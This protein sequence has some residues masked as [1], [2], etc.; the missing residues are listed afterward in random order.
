[1]ALRLLAERVDSREQ[2]D[3]CLG[4]GYSLFQGYYLHGRPSSPG[5]ASNIRNPALMRLL[6]LI[7]EDA[8][9]RDPG[10]VRQGRGSRS[11]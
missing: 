1:M 10:G 11:T 7:V 9:T 5:A 4:L 3:F 2:A 8:E 6:N